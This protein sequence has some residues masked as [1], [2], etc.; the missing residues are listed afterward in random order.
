V[1]D[2]GTNPLSADS[3][4]GGLSD[5]NEVL[6]LDTNPSSGDNDGDGSNDN[7]ELGVGTRPND[8]NS[9]P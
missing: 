2:S 5:G 3:D 9:F 1:F 6:D 8:P 7:T 4:G